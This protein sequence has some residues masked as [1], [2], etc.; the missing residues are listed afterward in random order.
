MYTVMSTA[1]QCDEKVHSLLK[2][3]QMGGIWLSARGHE[4][5]GA[6]I[7]TAL[8]RTDYL[9]TYYRGLPEQLA[10]GMSLNEMW[11]EWLGKATGSCKGKGGGIHVVDPEAGV[12][13][14]SG[15][16]GA[17]LPIA[18]GLAL[19]SQL[20]KDGRVTVCTFGDGAINQGSF[21]ES[22]NLAGLWK[23]PVVFFCENNRYAETTA[24]AKATSAEQIVDR[25]A[26][27]QIPGVKVD[28]ND[29]AATYQ[30]AREAVDRAR[31]GAGPTLIEATAYRLMGHYNLD[32]MG[33]IPSE[34]LAAAVAA[35]PVPAFRARLVAAGIASDEDLAAIDKR[36]AEEVEEA[37]AFAKTSPDPDLEELLRD[38]T[39]VN[40]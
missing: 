27:Y 13:S 9:V 2:S 24:Y 40:Q 33:Y 30:A 8:E 12:M 23:L 17:G 18:S 10:K 4:A 19:A 28:G 5:V 34:E 21:H 1:R 14:N 39:E 36:A 35:D 38:V 3:G 26:A 16:I 22:L 32:T 25:A 15:I 7:G 20:R 11:A 31:A 6:A 37:W 29:P